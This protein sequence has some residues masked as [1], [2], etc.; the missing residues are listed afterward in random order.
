MPQFRCLGYNPVFASWKVRGDKMHPKYYIGRGLM[1]RDSCN[2]K[3][4]VFEIFSNFESIT[5]SYCWK[6]L[7]LYGV[8]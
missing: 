6:G 2:G 4:K 3:N 7:A 5:L 1:S 8:C